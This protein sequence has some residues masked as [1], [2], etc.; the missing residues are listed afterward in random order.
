MLIFLLPTLVRG[1]EKK[2]KGISREPFVCRGLRHASRARR[3]KFN[4]C[5]AT[6]GALCVCVCVSKISEAAKYKPLKSAEESTLLRS[7]LLNMF[8]FVFAITFTL[9]RQAA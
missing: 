9:T 3:I 4:K 7:T 1:Y 5:E 8:I 2:N 6:P